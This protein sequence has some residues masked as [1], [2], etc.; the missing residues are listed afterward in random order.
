MSGSS[1]ADEDFDTF[2]KQAVQGQDAQWE[3][4]E[5]EIQRQE[6]EF[7]RLWQERKAEIEQKW[8]E[9]LR[10]TNKEWVDY[11]P[12]LDARSYVNFQEGFVEVTVV[13]PAAGK[14][15][16]SKTEKLIAKQIK[17]IFSQNNP[18]G[19]N[20]LQNQVTF[21]PNRVVSRTTLSKFIDKTKM[22][23]TFH[24]AP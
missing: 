9:A 10:S 8:D 19:T 13:V 1:L 20:V 15:I 3:E 6:A 14:D 5:K 2:W 18:S 16:S 21:G 4:H 12:S 24:T 7:E 22:K 17:K 11:S 23:P